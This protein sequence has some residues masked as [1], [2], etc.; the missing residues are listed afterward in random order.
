MCTGEFSLVILVLIVAALIG[1]YWLGSSGAVCEE[2]PVCRCRGQ[3]AP[4]S[5]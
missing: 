1:G 5:L 4:L 3:F 2:R